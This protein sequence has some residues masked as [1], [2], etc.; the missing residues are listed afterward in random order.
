MKLKLSFEL[1]RYVVQDQDTCNFYLKTNYLLTSKHIVVIKKYYF[2]LLYI[3]IFDDFT[4]N[5]VCD[6]I[7]LHA[8]K[9]NRACNK[10]V[11]DQGRRTR[12]GSV[13]N[14]SK[15]SKMAKNKEKPCSIKTHF[16]TRTRN[17]ALGIC[18]IVTTA[19]PEYEFKIIEGSRELFHYKNYI[20]TTTTILRALDGKKVAPFL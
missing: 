13:G 19:T 2:H 16:Y 8:Q 5:S 6:L 11:E 3:Y 20:H 12:M 18:S 10:S 15:L 14:R 7:L 17:P 1:S 4:R 9:F